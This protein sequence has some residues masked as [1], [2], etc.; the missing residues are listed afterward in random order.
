MTQQQINT[1]QGGCPRF[2][3]KNWTHED[4][5]NAKLALA[6][7]IRDNGLTAKQFLKKEFKIKWLH[8]YLC[9]VDKRWN[10]IPSAEMKTSHPRTLVHAM[11]TY[12][13]KWKKDCTAVQKVIEALP[14]SID[15]TASFD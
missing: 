13:L 10:D 15:Q 8:Q 11:N 2:L 14:E 6:H 12:L 7:Y 1:T 9:I 4:K 3:T 5:E